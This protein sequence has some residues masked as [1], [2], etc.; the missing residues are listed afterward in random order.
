MKRA[1]WYL[2]VSILTILSVAAWAAAPAGWT[3]TTSTTAD[4]TGCVTSGTNNGL[5]AVASASGAQLWLWLNGGTPVQLYPSTGIAPT[6]LA[7]TCPSVSIGTSGLSVP[8]AT[9]CTITLLK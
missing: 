7:I 4:S 3:F 2:V 6:Q 1:K 5:C 9:P 8:T